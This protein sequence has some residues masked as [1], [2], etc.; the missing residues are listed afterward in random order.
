M[1]FIIS[2]KESLQ[3]CQQQQLVDTIVNCLCS[4]EG[5]FSLERIE[6]ALLSQFFTEPQVICL[7]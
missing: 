6:V 5:Y 2:W 1:L 4:P 3:F 7:Q